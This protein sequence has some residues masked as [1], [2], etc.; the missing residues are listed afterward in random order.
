M[1]LFGALQFID[2]TVQLT[3]ISQHF[4]GA[5]D[6]VRGDSQQRHALPVRQ[7]DAHQ[8]GLGAEVGGQVLP[9]LLHCYLICALQRFVK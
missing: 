8:P 3:A 9:Q 7:Q 6:L 5:A 1:Q 2:S 4:A